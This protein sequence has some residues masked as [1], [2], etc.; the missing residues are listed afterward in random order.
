MIGRTFHRTERTP[1][2]R[3][4]QCYTLHHRGAHTIEHSHE[5]GHWVVADKPVLIYALTPNGP[6]CIVSEPGSKPWAAPRT[7]HMVIALE[8]GDT[9]VRCEFATVADFNLVPSYQEVS[10]IENLP[11]FVRQALEA[12]WR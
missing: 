11:A 6:E 12:A 5:G 9:N 7:E 2:G 1:D 4:V 3:A 8:D 10:P